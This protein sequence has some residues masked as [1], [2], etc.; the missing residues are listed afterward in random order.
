MNTMKTKFNTFLV[1]CV[2]RSRFVTVYCPRLQFN[3]TLRVCPDSWV[4]V[5]IAEVRWNKAQRLRKLRARARQ[6]K[7]EESRVYE[8]I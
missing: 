2:G 8:T 7:L 1:D 4:A 5:R 3:Q 6:R